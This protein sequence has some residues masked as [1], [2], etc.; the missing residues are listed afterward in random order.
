[1][2]LAEN[3]A[4]AEAAIEYVHGLEIRSATRG[5]FGPPRTPERDEAQARIK[6]QEQKAASL[7]DHISRLVRKQIGNCGEMAL[8]AANHL[9]GRGIY[10]AVVQSKVQENEK[11]W[12]GWNHAFLVIGANKKLGGIV[13]TQEN[14]PDWGGEAVI[15]D[16]WLRR[17]SLLKSRR[18]D[19]FVGIVHKDWTRYV[20]TF[21]KQTDNLYRSSLKQEFTVSYDFNAPA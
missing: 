6:R 10:L 17:A 12:Q 9:A 13:L 14:A 18:I 5:D 3:R 15:C 11:L 21:R 7:Q 2:A 20:K 4:A 16:P 19:G 8:L 1:M